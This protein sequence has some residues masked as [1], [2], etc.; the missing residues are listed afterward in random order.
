ME[1]L[2]RQFTNI[3]TSFTQKILDYFE[4]KRK[5][6]LKIYFLNQ[7]VC[8]KKIEAFKEIKDIFNKPYICRV[9]KKHIFNTMNTQVVLIPKKA[10]FLDENKKVIHINCVVYEGVE[11]NEI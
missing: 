11:L 5:W 6:K 10:L 1:E 8:T 9:H 3:I 2:F 7:L 4:D